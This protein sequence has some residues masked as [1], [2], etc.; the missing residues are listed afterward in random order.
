MQTAKR[1]LQPQFLQPHG[2]THD[3]RGPSQAAKPRRVSKLPQDPSPHQCLKP[4]RRRLER[5]PVPTSHLVGSPAR[6]IS[7]CSSSSKLLLSSSLAYWLQRAA[8]RGCAATTTFWDELHQA[9]SKGSYVRHVPSL[10]HPQPSRLQKR[11]GVWKVCS[12]F[13]K[14]VCPWETFPGRRQPSAALD[15]CRYFVPGCVSVAATCHTE[16][17]W[18]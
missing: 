10:Q 8:R 3:K 2:R 1:N 9:S 18:L 12:P 11:G 15:A 16:W 7:P 6:T 4:R 5:L 17:L 14:S 13:P